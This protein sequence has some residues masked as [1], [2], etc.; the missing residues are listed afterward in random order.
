MAGPGYLIFMMLRYTWDTHYSWVLNLVIHLGS[1]FWPHLVFAKKEN[2]ILAAQLASWQVT[3]M[4]SCQ[5]SVCRDAMVKLNSG[6]VTIK[7]G[8]CERER[9]RHLNIVV[10][11]DPGTAVLLPFCS[12]VNLPHYSPS[13][14]FNWFNRPCDSIILV[15]FVN[16]S[17]G[18]CLFVDLEAGMAIKE[19]PKWQRWKVL[20]HQK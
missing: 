7:K 3:T 9:I 15:R 4:V 2:K 16:L 6:L 10:A 8:W 20:Y 11:V 14:S 5:L 19:F 18:A 12:H 17:R 13:V 1:S